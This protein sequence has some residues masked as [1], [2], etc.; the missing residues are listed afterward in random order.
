MT[1]AHADPLRPKTIEVD[2]FSDAP[3]DDW[4]VAAL[5]VASAFNGTA[6]ELTF[7]FDKTTGHNGDKLQLTITRNKAGSVGGSELRLSSRVNNMS[8]S[9]WWGFVA[10]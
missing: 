7:A 9:E 3:A 4:T 1:R 10:N 5:D 2:L 8:V 6:A